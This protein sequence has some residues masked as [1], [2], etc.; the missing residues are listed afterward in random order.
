[1]VRKEKNAAL[2]KT[3]AQAAISVRDSNS[4]NLPSTAL[5]EKKSLYVASISRK[6]H[7]SDNV[8]HQSVSSFHTV[9]IQAKSAERPARGTCSNKADLRRCA[10]SA[11]PAKDAEP[12]VSRSNERIKVEIP[13]P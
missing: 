10:S 5:R 8:A 1:M 3:E 6:D 9:G 11:S 2:A 4:V 12:G 13:A 7:E